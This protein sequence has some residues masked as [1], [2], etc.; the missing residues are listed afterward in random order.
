M[1][2]KEEIIKVSGIHPTR[3]LN[4]YLF[5][6]RVYG[7]S[8]E[9][10][11]WD[12]IMI[13]KTSSPETEIKTDK[14]NIHVLTPDRFQDGLD[15][16]NIRNIECIMAPD[17]AKLQENHKFKFDLVFN[18]LRHSVSHMNSNS[19]VKCKK[20]LQQGDY[21]IGIKSIWHSMRMVM[22]GSQIARYGKIV[23][24]NCANDIWKE[25]MSK[26]WTWDELDERFRKY[27]NELLSGFRIFATK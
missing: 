4:I 17:W 27:N 6:S 26:T 5:G 15:Q 10:S 23:D 9:S 21:Y 1:I 22:F 12:V 19:W 20:K 25:I 11:D 8:T 16:H 14:F 7:N 2:T 3:I 24:W 13:A 18:R